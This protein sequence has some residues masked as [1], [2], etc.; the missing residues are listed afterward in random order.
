MK[1]G[2]G[3]STISAGKPS[4]KAV[5][6]SPAAAANIGI[7]ELYTGPRPPDH[8]AIGG[9][10]PTCTTTSYSSGSQGKHK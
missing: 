5:G 1:Q 4:T 7:I 3:N 6:V 9:Y 8:I 2:T 10:A